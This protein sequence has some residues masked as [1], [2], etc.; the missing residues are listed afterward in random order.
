MPN[1]T[2]SSITL[3]NGNTYDI[4]DKNASGGNTWFG[5][6]PT[7]ANTAAKVVTTA[8]ADFIL[9]TGNIVFI[10]FTYGNTN[11]SATISVDSSTA[12]S[13][14][15]FG[16]T[17]PV[18]GGWADGAVVAFVYDGTNFIQID[19]STATTTV[20]GITKLTDSTAST[21]TTTAATAKSVK[22][23]LDSAKAY[24]DSLV[25]GKAYQGV[26]NS[27]SEISGLADYSAGWYWV[28]GT[29]GTYAGQTCESG[30]FIFCVED[31][32]SSYSASDFKAVQGNIDISIFGELAYKDTASATYTPAG[33]VSQPTFSGTQ[34]SVS[35]TT[36][37]AVTE[38]SVNTTASGGTAIT[39]AGTISKGTGTANYTPEGTVSQPTFNGTTGSV[40][41]T[42]SGAVTAVSGSVNTTESGG[43]DI[44][45]AGTVSTPTIT[46]TPSTGTVNS[47]T[48]VGTSPSWTATV[49]NENLTIGW[50]AGTLPTKGSDTLVV[51][52]ITSATSTQPTFT[53]TQKYLHLSTTKD[54]VT[55]TGSF[56]PDGTVSQPTFSG[57]GAEL[58]FTGTEKYIHTTKG[59]V[60]STGNF[61]PSGTVTQ[62]TFS[63]TE[64]TITV[65]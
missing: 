6:C 33:T 59:T 26:V 13:I 62:P 65:S 21:S 15:Q 8:T 30:D 45:P 24:A 49:S 5:T 37:G 22:D 50:S 58:K 41:V 10:K 39:P 55:S 46:V 32:D 36:S 60:T 47:I 16:T 29:A 14:K 44:K 54:T 48:D 25:T 42:T 43:V 11:T 38:V 34:G 12:K 63:G 4:R 57:T 1:P 18:N 53:G 40:S 35:V 51:T 17:A 31:M 61:T 23:A 3:P 27:P 28:V 64:A 9:D 19:G 2:I 52:G 7:A 20:Y 56:T